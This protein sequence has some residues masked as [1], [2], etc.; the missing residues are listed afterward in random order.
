MNQ[1]LLVALLSLRLGVVFDLFRLGGKWKRSS[2][3]EDESEEEMIIEWWMSN[4]CLYLNYLRLASKSVLDIESRIQVL[5]VISYSLLDLMRHLD[6]KIKPVRRD[7]WEEEE[8]D[9]T[10]RRKSGS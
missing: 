4:V 9:E 6:Q 3:E 2:F 5:V 10:Y 1:D 7:E 8:K